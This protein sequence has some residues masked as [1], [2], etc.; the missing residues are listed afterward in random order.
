M[1]TERNE[2]S[3][4]TLTPVEKLTE[5]V[6][7]ERQVQSLRGRSWLECVVEDDLMEIILTTNPS[8]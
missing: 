4:F 3:I 5:K 1:L 6:V 2:P 7:D 8:Q